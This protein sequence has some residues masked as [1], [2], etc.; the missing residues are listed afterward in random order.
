MEMNGVRPVKTTIGCGAIRGLTKRGYINLLMQPTG[1][2]SE[3]VT[4]LQ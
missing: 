1:T 3:C 4:S 2:A